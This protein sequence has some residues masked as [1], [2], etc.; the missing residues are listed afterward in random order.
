MIQLCARDVEHVLLLIFVLH[1]QMDGMENV[2]RFP[3]VMEFLQMI[4]LMS[5]LVVVDALH[6]ML[7]HALLNGQDRCVKLQNVTESLKM[8]L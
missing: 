8:I 2:V 3:S 7:V 5:V 1:V 4:P 6:Q